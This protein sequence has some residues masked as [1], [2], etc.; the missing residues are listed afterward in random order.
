MLYETL[1][2]EARRCDSL[3]E[4][5]LRALERGRWLVE[6]LEQQRRGG[7]GSG[8]A[9][10]A[11]VERLATGV[12]DEE[13]R[14]ALLCLLL[15]SRYEETRDWAYAFDADA[16]VRRVRGWSAAEVAVLFVRVTECDRGY[17][18]ADSLTVA[19]PAAEQL[20]PEALRE[21]SP[22]LRALHAQMRDQSI[23]AT[24]K[25]KLNRRLRDLLGSIEE[26]TVPHGLIPDK[27]PWAAPLRNRVAAAPTAGLAALIR[28]FVALSS[29]R[30]T[31]KWRRACQDLVER[32]DARD[33]VAD[34]L[35][36]LA[37]GDTLCTRTHGEHSEAIGG[38]YHYHYV[39]HQND[40]DLARGA[41]WA[42]ALADGPAAVPHLVALAL[43][44]S[45]TERGIVEDLK[46][47]GAAINALG[48]TGDQTSLEAL[49]RLR[50]R[51]RHR[52]LRK[53]LDTALTTA[54]GK[55]GITPEQLVERSVPDHGLGPD[56]A[57]ER[58][59]GEHTLRIAIE[60]GTTVRLTIVRPDGTP[61]RT[62]P[63]AVKDGHPDALKRHKAF[64]KE[65][66]T[67]LASERV[68]VEALMSTDREWPYDEW[69]RHYRD[70][71]VTGGI[72]HGLIWEF[73]A[74]DGP[75]QAVAPGARPDGSPDRVRLWHP[76]R[77][78]A[79]EVA[80]W[81]ER[82]M[83]DKLRQPFKQAFREIYLLTPAE[84]ETRVYSN[85]FAAHIV[86]YQQLYALFKERGWQANYLSG[87][88]GG[89]EGEA[90][91]VFADGAWRAVFHHDPADEDFPYSPDHAATDQVRFERRSGKQWR[92]VPLADVPPQVFS[93]AMRDVDLFVGVTSIAA[94]A[95]WSDR[96]EDRHHAYWRTTTFGALTASA[97]VRG[98]ALQRIL[99]RLRIA[100]RCTLDGRF[101]RV[102]GELTTYKIHLG[103]ANILMEPDDAYLCIVPGR[104]PSA[105][106][107]V[108]LPFEDERLSLI[109]SKALLLAADTKIKD[110]TIVR[111]IK[112]GAR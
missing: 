112:R 83:A 94:D 48:E 26:T 106:G 5:R 92:E 49:W 38:A 16:L 9:R 60:H 71:P 33:L 93:E 66:R 100:D 91:G 40:G 63:A 30:P 31:Q 101:L 41:V 22:H 52:A 64:A 27:A 75:W 81:R 62:A 61:S 37:E 72:V 28:H 13:G 77:A 107:Q 20:A 58:E 86:H 73:R 96:G 90:R 105:G 21:V 15:G 65:L 2:A 59:L 111:Q 19:L 43:R 45:G 42:V 6:L 25:A 47:A 10:A 95:E 44:V 87:H 89:Y 82:L 74:G 8:A 104:R 11:M 56:G 29:P 36:E 99:P 14:A 39:A 103:S 1:V 67:T 97:E 34:V 51:I 12:G 108:F 84:D 17:W 69:C 102:R 32:A 76:I 23:D 78:E 98:A 55:L 54:A 46:L 109:L 53:Q 18:F 7:A 24:R 57:V 70:H 85:R 110:E 4:V 50:T 79:G 35:R 3:D 88:D 80:A 68:R